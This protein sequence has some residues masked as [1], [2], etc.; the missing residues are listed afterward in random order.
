MGRKPLIA[1]NWKMNLNHIDATGLV[2]KLD[3]ALRDHK[4]DPERSECVVI[5]PFTDLRTVQTLIE[6]DRMPIGLGAQ[7]V[8][9]HAD[10]A[11]TGD[12][13][14][15]MLVKLCCRYVIVGHSE[16]RLYHD[17][18]DA[19]VNQK[20]LCC[21]A[22]GLSPIVCVGEGLEIRQAGQHV[23]HTVDQVEAALQGV[24]AGDLASLVIAYEPIW[25]IG[26]GQVA[27]PDDA[28]EVCAAIRAKVASLYGAAEAEEVRVLYG[29]SV[30]AGTAG[31]LMA[32]PDIDGALVGGASLNGEEF[33]LITR[34]YDLPF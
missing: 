33:A 23:E 18:N 13:S 12:I 24:K 22:N 14:A 29:G 7:D 19:L 34:F 28:Q 25:A 30:K 15:T 4:Y 9:P 27:T 20:A 26:T 3:W 1:G 16:R 8:S 11:Y 32:Q 31:A 2:Q 10:G 6:G 17:E 5:P 21:L